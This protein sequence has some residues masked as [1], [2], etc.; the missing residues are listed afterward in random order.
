MNPLPGADRKMMLA[1]RTNLEVVVQF[2]VEHHRFTLRTLG[3]K[4]FWDLLLLLLSSPHLRLLDKGRLRCRRRRGHRR[5]N[6]EAQTFVGVR[7]R[8]HKNLGPHS[9]KPRANVHTQTS[10][11]PPANRIDAHA[12]VVAPVVR[13]SSI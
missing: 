13:T 4:P 6:I 12:L 8:R 10:S 1:L 7:G 2:L 3:P 5:F 9:N 11:A